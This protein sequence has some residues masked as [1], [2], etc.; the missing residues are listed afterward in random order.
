MIRRP[1]RSTLFPYTTLFRSEKNT[2]AHNGAMVIID[3][4]TGEVLTMIGSRDYFNEDI[5]GKNNNA[6]SLNSP[7]SSFKPFVYLMAFQ[8]LGWGPGTL[9]LDTPVCFK[10]ADGSCFSPTNPTHTYNGPITLR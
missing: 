2:G 1:P 6:T 8:K 5:Q 4:K 10:E 7:G 9:A 3:P